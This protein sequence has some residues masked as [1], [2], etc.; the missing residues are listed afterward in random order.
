MKN[1]RFLSL[2]GIVLVC[3]FTITACGDDDSNDPPR[4]DVPT[5]IDPIILGT[6]ETYAI[7]PNGGSEIAV[8]SHDESV[9][10]YWHRFVFKAD[11]SFDGYSVNYRGDEKIRGR[12]EQTFITKTFTF[13]ASKKVLALLNLVEGYHD[14]KDFKAGK[15]VK[16]Q[17]MVIELK[18]ITDK[19]LSYNVNYD[20]KQALFK[21]KKV[22]GNGGD[23]GNGGG[24]GNV[25]ASMLLGSWG[26][27]LIAGSATDIETGNVVES[28]NNDT[29]NV[30]DKKFM[31][32]V[33]SEN[34]N[35]EIFSHGDDDA[36]QQELV[37]MKGNWTLNGNM[38]HVVAGDMVLEVEIITLDENNLTFH[39]SLQKQFRPRHSE[40]TYFVTYDET[41]YLKRYIIS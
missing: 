14:V 18:T 34:G 11:G 28:W 10:E 22:D 38:C 31:C 1:F 39:Y 3:L 30:S 35:L 8:N 21:M 5:G 33:F 6:W 27:T 40:Q 36:E 7:V 29:P 19:E 16:T 25:S 12:I 37:S 13:S 26:T 32:F 15:S 17:D 23:S 2:L 4:P 41:I 9:Y 20:G 24:N